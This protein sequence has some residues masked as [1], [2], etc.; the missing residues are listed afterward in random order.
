MEQVNIYLM[1]QESFNSEH[2][3]KS[4]ACSTVLYNNGCDNAYTV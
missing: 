2:T 3:V 1:S 4:Y